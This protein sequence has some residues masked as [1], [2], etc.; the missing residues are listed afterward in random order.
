MSG[1]NFGCSWADC[2]SVFTRKDALM[3]HIKTV[4]RNERNYLCDR[5]KCGRTFSTVYL[6]QRHIQGVHQKERNF[7][8]GHCHKAFALLQ[9]LRAHEGAVH[10]K[11]IKTSHNTIRIEKQSYECAECGS[12]FVRR[13][14]LVAH[15]SEIHG[16]NER[17]ECHTCGRKYSRKRNLKKHIIDTHQDRVHGTS[18]KKSRFYCVICNKLFQFRH[19]LE[20]HYQEFHEINFETETLKFSCKEDFLDW[21]KKFE[22]CSTTRFSLSRKCKG[23]FVYVCHRSGLRK[24]KSCNRKRA[25]ILR[26][27]KKLHGVCPASITL[28]LNS[29][30]SCVATF[31]KTHVGHQSNDKSELKHCFLRPED[32]EKL[33]GMVASGI[34]K[35]RILNDQLKN[36]TN[37]L[38]DFDPT[39]VA[40]ND[41]LT[42]KDLCNV[43]NT[44]NV[45]T[46][47][48]FIRLYDKD[49]DNVEAFVEQYKDC[50][51]L[52][53]RK[54][55]KLDPAYED[56]NVA[57][58]D[59]ILIFMSP[60]QK[61]ML[62]KHS[63]IVCMD[64][65]HGTNPY[66]LLLHTLLV[67][68]YDG[69]GFP[70]AFVFSN[71]NDQVLIQIFARCLKLHVGEIV[72]EVFM[73]DMQESYVNGWSKEMG[74]PKTVLHCMY[75]VRQAWKKHLPKFNK[76]K[77][78]AEKYAQRKK[79]K[80]DLYELSVE[81]CKET[82]DE[83]LEEFLLPSDDEKINDFLTYFQREYCS[84]EKFKHW[85]YCYRLNAGV[86]TN[87]HLESFHK[88]LKYVHGCGR[89]MKDLFSGLNLVLQF[90]QAQI[91]SSCNKIVRGKI[92]PRLA[93]LRKAHKTFD[94]FRNDVSI[95]MT[96]ESHV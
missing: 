21:K 75:H 22:D 12:N 70:A 47:E 42:N 41:L 1:C 34:P 50:V 65:T 15:L 80:Q 82:F 84:K 35:R 61:K 76:E 31:V 58:D 62:Q 85:A 55:E 66:G 9:N 20:Q 59:I 54:K 79:L 29:D 69:E 57:D 72:P 46:N 30:S 37:L 63:N 26:G 67:L 83:K 78:D 71:R 5:L 60:T 73:T 96:E 11:K 48:N 90:V 27:S 52:Y 94:K 2:S 87:T 49:A 17:F 91:V 74:V 25:H 36:C 64:G 32:R 88:T 4:H 56:I 95:S 77:K 53:K 28:H 43:E 68:D 6:L 89:N 93:A 3:R 51:L 40:R 18:K 7:S 92:T 23:K 45:K 13:K 38:Y 19:Q 24:V 16:N 44:Y 8:C 10:G 39:S 86:N 14:S 33:A 81:T